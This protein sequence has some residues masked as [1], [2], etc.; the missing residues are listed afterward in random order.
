[1]KRSTF[2]K[3]F[4]EDFYKLCKKHGLLPTDVKSIVRDLDESLHTTTND[5]LFNVDYTKDD[6]DYTDFCELHDKIVQECIDF[7]NAHPE[8]QKEITKK[9]KEVSKSWN[10][11]YPAKYHI[12][13]DIRVLFGANVLEESIENKKWVPSTDSSLELC[14]GDVQILIS[15]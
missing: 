2:K 15:I 7:I 3:D 10:D 9:Q 4:I 6:E 14:V 5:R 12:T 1:M 8:V 11:G 13:P